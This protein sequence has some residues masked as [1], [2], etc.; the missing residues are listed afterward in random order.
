MH[1]A[2][3]KPSPLLA[4]YVKCF[5]V[6]EHDNTP[7]IA[8][9]RVMPDGCIEIVFNLAERF[10]RYHRDGTVEIQA[11]AIVAGQ[12]R[13]FSAIEP[14]GKIKLFGVRFRPAGAYPFFRFP[15]SDLTDRIEDLTAI[16][17]DGY[18]LEERLHEAAGDEERVLLLERHLLKLLAEN[19]KSDMI[20]EGAAAF[21]ASKSGVVSI[22]DVAK[23]LEVSGRRLERRFQQRF[24]TTPKFFSRIVRFQNLL[25]TLNEEQSSDLLGAALS[26]GYYDQAHLIHEFNEFAGESPAAFFENEYNFS[27]FFINSG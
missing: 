8:V 21:I 3:I 1:Y 7:E 10:R 2:E 27:Q 20:V 6:L 11:S 15:L 25:K 18:L 16:W 9:E 23:S 5:W 4:K 14:T 24:G 12:M 22:T 13:S 19:R 17:S 26:F